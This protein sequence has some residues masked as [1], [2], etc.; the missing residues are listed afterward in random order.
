MLYGLQID[1]FRA[2]VQMLAHLPSLSC[3]DEILAKHYRDLVDLQHHETNTQRDPPPDTTLTPLVLHIGKV[4][5]TL[6][7]LGNKL[8]KR[9]KLGIHRTIEE[10]ILRILQLSI[11][12]TFSDKDRKIP[13]LEEVRVSIEATKLLIRTE[14]ELHIISEKTYFTISAQPIEASKMTNGW[15]RSLKNKA[16]R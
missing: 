4:Y 6:Y 14:H 7:T 5:K 10:T 9:D 13:Y 15:L 8:S 3:H 16:P 1:S 2:Q 12:G 11:K